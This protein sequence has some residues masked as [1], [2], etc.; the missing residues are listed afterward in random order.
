MMSRIGSNNFR[1]SC[2]ASWPGAE[3]RR[4][5]IEVANIH[6]S[7][8]FPFVHVVDGL[9]RLALTESELHCIFP[10]VFVI[11]EEVSGTSKWRSSSSDPQ[12]LLQPDTKTALCSANSI[13]GKKHVLGHMC[14][15]QLG[16]GTHER[17]RRRQGN[18]NAFFEA[19]L[20]FSPKRCK[21]T[22]DLHV[23]WA[24][25]TLR[26]Y[27]SRLWLFTRIGPRDRAWVEPTQGWPR[28]DGSDEAATIYAGQTQQTGRPVSTVAESLW[29]SLSTRWTDHATALWLSSTSN[30]AFVRG[31]WSHATTRLWISYLWHLCSTCKL[32]L[33]LVIGGLLLSLYFWIDRALMI[34]KI[35]S[36][37]HCR[38]LCA[39]DVTCCCQSICCTSRTLDLS[40]DEAVVTTKQS[41]TGTVAWHQHFFVQLISKE[42]VRLSKCFIFW[43]FWASKVMTS[44][45]PY[46]NIQSEARLK[47]SLELQCRWGGGNCQAP[48]HCMYD[49]ICSC[50]D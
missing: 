45:V 13:R 28:K 8:V 10:G 49:C 38:F 31:G 35:F 32:L 1:A 43:V 23:I 4:G 15:H 17:E 37:N 6:E 36:R 24:Y 33:Y 30:E 39:Q 44:R 5:N 29:Y 46:A 50:T 27:C 11:S 48:C 40:Q 19:N 14:W 42:T 3:K 22:V 21:K 9:I 12:L 25:H 47:L 2:A 26:W 34:C 41:I 16:L 20:M 7:T 18:A